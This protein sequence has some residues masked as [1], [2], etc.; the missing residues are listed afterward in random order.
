M[1]GSVKRYCTCV[2]PSTGRQLGAKCP[3]LSDSK[4]G[5]WNYRER[6]TTSTG[7]RE[8]RRRG[9]ATRTAANKFRDDVHALVRLAAGDPGAETRI[10]DLIFDRTKRG[11][12]LPDAEDVKRRLGLRGPLDRSMTL[13]EWLEQWIDG[14]RKLRDSTNDS[15]AGHIRVYLKPM[16][17]HIPLDRLAEQHIYDMFDRIEEWNTEIELAKQEGRKPACDGDQRR[18][19]M[20]VGIATQHRIFATLRNALNAARKSRR[21]DVNVC[22]FVE[23]EPETR[24]PARVWTPEQ[25]GHFLEFTE[26]DRLHLLWRLVL[27]RGLRRGEAIGLR[28][29]DRVAE[30]KVLLIR[31]T[32]L[33]VAGRVVTGVPKTRAGEREVTLDAESSRLFAL[34]LEAQ[35][36]DRRAL[37]DAYSDL[38]LVFAWE[39]G[40]PLRP[41]YV[42]RR[43]KMLSVAA[44]LPEITLHMGR[45][46]AATLGLEAGLDVKV[47]SDQLGHANTNITRNLY[48]HVRRAVHDAAAEAVVALLP[49]RVPRPSE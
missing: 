20:T 21:V 30:G 40:T 7:V 16:L 44:S 29:E 39:D 47:V 32:I 36:E 22:E 19:S 17:G 8:M 15:Y 33:Q 35:D 24:L 46:T 14:K 13:G 26:H 31:S 38:D 12:Q 45:H 5:E 9:F 27:L 41:D 23:L 3:S 11:G 48:Q 28:R 2:D 6:L 34:H 25:V 4:H 37:G 42:T 1:K 18:R 10:V 49:P 43:F